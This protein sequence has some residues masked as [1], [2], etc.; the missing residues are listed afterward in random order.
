MMYEI[1]T[2][3][4]IDNACDT[5]KTDNNTYNTIHTQQYRETQPARYSST[6]PPLKYEDDKLK[7]L[8]NNILTNKHHFNRN[9]TTK[10]QYTNINKIYNNIYK[11]RIR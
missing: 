7:Q 2:A 5:Y 3:K 6:H 10:Y 1:N 9:L 8:D 4:L 11:Y